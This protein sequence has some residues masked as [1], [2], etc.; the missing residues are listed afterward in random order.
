M[1]LV[2]TL[3]TFPAQNGFQFRFS[4]RSL[5]WRELPTS[6]AFLPPSTPSLTPHALWPFLIV[7]DIPASPLTL[8]RA[9]LWF[10]SH[11][12]FLNDDFLI[13]PLFKDLCFGEFP[14]SPCL[15]RHSHL[16]AF[17]Y[18][19]HHLTQFYTFLYVFAL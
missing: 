7:T 10:S 16:H 19:C 9:F 14:R 2:V 13:K 15:T 17:P 18:R 4:P 12:G 11:F 5:H 8:P 1:L 3:K 6:P